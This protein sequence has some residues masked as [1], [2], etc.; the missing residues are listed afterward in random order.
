MISGAEEEDDAPTAVESDE[1]AMSDD[2]D[3]DDSAEP[4]SSNSQTGDLS[5]SDDV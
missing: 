2:A 4:G 5:L 1:E 3:S